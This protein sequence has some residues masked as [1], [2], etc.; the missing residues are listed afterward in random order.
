[1]IGRRGDGKGENGARRAGPRFRRGEGTRRLK[2]IF[3]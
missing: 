1:M 3:F 2:K